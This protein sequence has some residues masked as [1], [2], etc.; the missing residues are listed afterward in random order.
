MA[1]LDLQVF[2]CA[3]QRNVID[4]MSCFFHRGLPSPSTV[5]AT[6]PAL[7]HCAWKPEGRREEQLMPQQACT[8]LFLLSNGS[9]STR[10][11]GSH[12]PIRVSQKHHVSVRVRSGFVCR[13]GGF[14]PSTAFPSNQAP[15]YCGCPAG[16]HGCDP[17]SKVRLDQSANPVVVWLGLVSRVVRSSWSHGAF[18]HQCLH[19]HTP[20]RHGRVT[21]WPT[22]GSSLMLIRLVRIGTPVTL[23]FI[24]TSLQHCDLDGFVVTASVARHHRL[25]TLHFHWQFNNL[26]ARIGPVE[27]L[28]RS[29]FGHVHVLATE[30]HGYQVDSSCFDHSP[31]APKSRQGWAWQRCHDQFDTLVIQQLD[32]VMTGHQLLGSDPLSFFPL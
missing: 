13:C 16:T 2:P 7:A 27:S 22:L 11:V 12:A 20:V 19:S 18:I 28:A 32:S 3:R 26:V 31:V 21:S 17:V 1:G 25:L 9:D 6:C 15:V 5:G 23:T 4:A 8:I 30:T 14:G 24:V 29:D 10:E